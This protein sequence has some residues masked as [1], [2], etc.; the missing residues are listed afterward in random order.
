LYFYILA[1]VDVND[2]YNQTGDFKAVVDAAIKEL[3]IVVV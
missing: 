2:L 3:K 1:E